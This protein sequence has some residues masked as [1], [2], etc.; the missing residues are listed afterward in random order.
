MTPIA[1]A[2][3]EALAEH[4]AERDGA[5]DAEAGRQRNRVV[6]DQ[7]HRD[8]SGRP[9]TSAVARRADGGRRRQSPANMFDR[10][11]GFRKRM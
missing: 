10:M 6:A 5:V 9:A 7:A 11:I 3:R 1:P 4:Q 2:G 8:A